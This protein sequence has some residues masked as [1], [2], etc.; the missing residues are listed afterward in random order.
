MIRTAEI[1]EAAVIVR[2]N[3]TFLVTW[4]H[5]SATALTPLVMCEGISGSNPSTRY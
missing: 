3:E 2:P 5:L 4:N 1:N